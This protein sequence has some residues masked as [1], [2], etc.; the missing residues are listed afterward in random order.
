MELMLAV[1][2]LVVLVALWVFLP[3][4]KKAHHHSGAPSTAPKAQQRA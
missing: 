2:M 4:E 3:G 1:L